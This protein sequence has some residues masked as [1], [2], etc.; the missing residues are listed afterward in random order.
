MEGRD[1]DLY[2][3]R[4][5]HEVCADL[6]LAVARLDEPLGRRLAAL[7]LHTWGGGRARES[8]VPPGGADYAPLHER[9]RGTMPDRSVRG[10]KS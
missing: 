5:R 8:R 6:A 9:L 3:E 10:R 7:T 2:G 4:D 1:L